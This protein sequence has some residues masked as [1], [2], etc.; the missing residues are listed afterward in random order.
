MG[1]KG[2]MVE[3]EI[4]EATVSSREGK[5]IVISRKMLRSHLQLA[6]VLRKHC[7]RAAER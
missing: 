4:L 6:A 3:D 2:Q 7:C 5:W 1:S